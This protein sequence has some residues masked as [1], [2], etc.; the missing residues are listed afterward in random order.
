MTLDSNKNA[1]VRIPAATIESLG[2]VRT[3]TK[4]VVFPGH[5]ELRN[6][7]LDNNNGLDKSRAKVNVMTEGSLQA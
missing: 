4:V 5:D 1:F 3:S 7:F 2:L 6:V